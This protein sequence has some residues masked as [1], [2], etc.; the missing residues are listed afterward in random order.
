MNNK[1]FITA[2]IAA[3][4]LVFAFSS[5]K[6]PKETG[7]TPGGRVP[8]DIIVDQNMQNGIVVVVPSPGTKVMQNTLV[9]VYA[10]PDEDYEVSFIRMNGIEL[11]ASGNVYTFNMPNVNANITAGFV[12]GG[13]TTQFIIFDNGFNDDINAYVFAGEHNWDNEL[14]IEGDFNIEDNSGMRPGT[15]GYKIAITDVQDYFGLHIAFDPVNLNSFDG[16]SLYARTTYE[17]EGLPTDK[18]PAINQVVFG[19]YTIDDVTEAGNWDYSIRYSGELNTGNALTT[20]WKKIIVP[21]PERINR[22]DCDTI[23]LY[24]TPAQ[25]E[26]LVIYIDQIRFIEAEEKELLSVQLPVSGSIPYKVLPSDSP[27]QTSLKILTMDTQLVYKIDKTTTITMFGKDGDPNVT[28]FLNNFTDFYNVTYAISSNSASAV[29]TGSAISANSAN[30]TGSAAPRLTAAYGG[31]T[32]QPMIVNVLDYPKKPTG[33]SM[34][35]EDFQN[36]IHPDPWGGKVILPLYWGGTAGD[37]QVYGEAGND[38]NWTLRC[39][40]ANITIYPPV[41]L[42]NGQPQDTWYVFGSLGLNHDLS[43]LSSITVRASMNNDIVFTFS[44]SSGYDGAASTLNSKGEKFSHRV[45]FIGKG[46]GWQE[47][48]IPLA[49]FAQAGVNLNCVTAFEFSTDRTLNMSPENIT[50]WSGAGDPTLEID[51]IIASE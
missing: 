33:G 24:F 21:L 51:S 50:G 30:I 47:Y 3:F 23:M 43:S 42:L 20:Q 31:K 13:T 1:F 17:A 35:L 22:N 44:L 28:Q 14:D 49:Q 32:S 34:I 29:I 8:H 11:E 38:G 25:V 4:V 26:G 37:A 48:N 27:I 46:K 16:L 10:Y 41:L 9:S 39:Y 36:L 12:L 15:K 45:D 7:T 19:K 18:E 2:C 40:T 5:C 6:E